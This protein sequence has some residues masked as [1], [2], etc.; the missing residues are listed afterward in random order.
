MKFFNKFI[1]SIIL[2]ILIGS[3]FGQPVL[4]QEEKTCAVFFTGESCPHCKK[5]E[6]EIARVLEENSNFVLI[7]YEV[8][9]RS[10]NAPLISKYSDFYG[11]KNGV[12][13]VI[14]DDGVLLVGD[15]Q[16][17]KQLE[18]YV[19]E[20]EGNPCPLADGTVAP[21]SQLELEDLA[22]NPEILNKDAKESDSEGEVSGAK[23]EKECEDLTL[24]KIISLGL[25]DSVNPCSIAVLTA[26]LLAILTYDPKKKHNVLLAGLAF[27]ASVFLMYLLYGLI[28]IRFF[29]LVQA[30]ASIRSILYKVLGVAAMF[31]GALNIKDFFEGGEACKVV[32]QIGSLLS[33][34]SSP[35]GAF[36]I[37]ALVT[38]FLLPCTIGPYV[39]CGGILSTLVIFKTL[40]WL[41][42]YNLIF[43][44]PMVAV[45]LAVYFGFS[46][47]ENVSGWQ[48][49]NIKYLNLA[50]GLIIFGLGVAMLFG[51]V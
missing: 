8:Y 50:S 35:K 51:L 24:A 38:V 11:A 41:V 17:T 39:I 15:R 21:Y 10:E 37:G 30:L 18:D 22:G 26:M 6:P 25:A 7:K 42:L 27:T 29:Q 34:I 43:V 4:A 49:K 31:V 28:I 3:F 2:V 14:F 48:A 44:L 47:V 40:P 23:E 1:K 36:S 33:R 46:T 20:Y 5:A 32:P 9:E 12:P 13:Q 19:R 16:I 45:T